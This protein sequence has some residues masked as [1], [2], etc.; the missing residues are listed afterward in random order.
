[1]RAGMDLSRHRRARL[2]TLWWMTKMPAKTS[3]RLAWRCVYAR[4]CTQGI[5]KYVVTGNPLQK[6]V[7]FPSPSPPYSENSKYGVLLKGF[8]A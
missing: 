4:Y 7:H 8:W 3:G 5:L 1:M 2:V 6:I